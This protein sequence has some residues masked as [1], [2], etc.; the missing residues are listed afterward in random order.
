MLEQL[1]QCLA[2]NEIYEKE[3]LSK[4][5]TFRIGG[6]AD[7]YLVPYGKESLKQVLSILKNYEIP[8]Y[9][10]GKGSNVL[11]G[12]GGFRGAVVE[13]GRGMEQIKFLTTVMVDVEAGISLAKLANIL[14]EKSLTGF[15]FASGIPGTV[16][17]A[18][19]MNAG[20]YGGEIRDCIKEAVVLDCEGNEKTLSRKELELGY[21]NSVIQRENYFVLS[22]V[23]EFERGDRE[24]IVA[25]MKELNSRRK[26]KQPLEYPSA[27]STFK[28]PRGY[29]AGQLIDDA[30][31]RGYSVGG[32]QVSEKHCGFVVNKGN[33]TAEDVLQ[34][35]RDVQEQVK[36]NSGV[37]LEPEVRLVGEF[38]KGRFTL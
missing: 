34:L 11:F 28:R 29:F 36:Q 16:G 7:L 37:L 14:A 17:G 1:R 6:P 4:H 2:E 35:I 19:T 12:D 21:R 5:T 3:P 27:G 23:F 33:A 15:E 10:L 32:A 30:G 26:E 8:V 25:R 22:A 38:L 9:L 20:A 24:T 13:I 18:V 31:L